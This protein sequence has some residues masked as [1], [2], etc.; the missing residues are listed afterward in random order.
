MT[1]QE[2]LR[3]LVARNSCAGL[4]SVQCSS[5]HKASQFGSR[6]RSTVRQIPGTKAPQGI[7]EFYFV[8]KFES[9]SHFSHPCC[10]NRL[11]KL[12]AEQS[13]CLEHSRANV[14][15]TEH[16]DAASGDVG[17]SPKNISAEICTLA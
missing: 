11:Q 7:D 6:C 3:T 13:P 15:K 5:C 12:H 16:K 1:G 14:M 10:N 2:A 8:R 4:R 9:P 17:S